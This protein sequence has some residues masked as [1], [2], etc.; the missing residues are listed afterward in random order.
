MNKLCSFCAK[1]NKNSNFKSFKNF[2][3]NIV[4]KNFNNKVETVIHEACPY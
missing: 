4:L 3:N 1:V 2:R